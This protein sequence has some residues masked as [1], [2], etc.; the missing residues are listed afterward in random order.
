M[1][2]SGNHRGYHFD[3]PE[4]PRVV[5]EDQPEVQCYEGLKRLP[6]QLRT[7]QLTNTRRKKQTT[8]TPTSLNV[9]IQVVIN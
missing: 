6:E 2:Y 3:S 4:T 9:R 1:A 5:Q 7:Q 8:K